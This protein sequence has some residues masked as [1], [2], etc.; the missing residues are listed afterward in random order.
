[1]TMKVGL[2]TTNNQYYQS[3][4][5]DWNLSDL[6]KWLRE[7]DRIPFNMSYDSIR[8]SKQLLLKRYFPDITFSNNYKTYKPNGVFIESFYR[9]NNS[10]SILIVPGD[11][12]PS[13][14]YYDLASVLFLKNNINVFLMNYFNYSE[15]KQIP[16]RSINKKIYLDNVTTAFKFITNNL[17]IQNLTLFGHSKAGVILQSFASQMQITNTNFILFNSGY[18]N[19]LVKQKINYYDYLD[20]IEENKKTPSCLFNLE[21]PIVLF[22]FLFLAP[23]KVK[24]SKSYYLKHFFSIDKF[25]YSKKDFIYQNSALIPVNVAKYGDIDCQKI[26]KNNRFL[27]IHSESDQ[28]FSKD[29]QTKGF[30]IFSEKT[31][32]SNEVTFKSVPGSHFS[33]IEE[34]DVATSMIVN[35]LEK[36]LL[37]NAHKQF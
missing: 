20:L 32:V 14:V 21:I 2:A 22:E 13:W 7:P 9:P 12:A 1:M 29:Y 33:C 31:P 3:N 27:F 10:H 18:G 35:F 36:G 11:T 34:P 6:E 26:G 5:K 25:S 23:N 24:F 8:K 19:N 17:K 37:Q 28:V 30:K 16:Y 15:S 4:N